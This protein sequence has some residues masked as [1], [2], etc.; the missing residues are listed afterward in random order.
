MR[1]CTILA[2]HRGILCKTHLIRRTPLN[3]HF[4][5]SFVFCLLSPS[6]CSHSA[7][8]VIFPRWCKQLWIH[9]V[10]NETSPTFLMENYFV[11]PINH[12]FIQILLLKL[13]LINIADDCSWCLPAFLPIFS[14]QNL[15]EPFKYFVAH[16]YYGN[17]V[18]KKSESSQITSPSQFV[19]NELNECSVK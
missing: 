4:G 5:L 15:F 9:Y 11:H 8:N 17:K 2:L 10:S 6:A 12:A 19:L 18:K 7:E 1:N 13:S 3:I 14:A 16:N